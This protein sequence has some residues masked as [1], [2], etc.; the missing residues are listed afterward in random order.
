MKN[1]FFFLILSIAGIFSSI[2]KNLPAESRQILITEFMA[3]NSKTLADEDGDA[4]DWIELYN[5]GDTSVNLSGWFLT[6]KADNLAKWEIPDITLGAGKYLLVFAS[7]KKRSDP[8]KNLHTNFKLS[9]SGEFLAIV[10]PDGT[11]ISCSF[12]EMF[13]A[14]QED[15]SYGLYLGQLV[16]FN[17]PT[18]G[19]E[20]IL[21]GQA[22]APQ[23]SQ[24]RG[25]YDAPFDVSLTIPGGGA[26]IYYT[27][28]GA[29]PTK[30]SGTLYQNPVHIQTTTPLSAVSI[31]LSNIP[32]EVITHTY[33]FI[34]SIVKQPDNPKGYPSEWSPFKFS[35]GN[36]PADYEMDPEVCNNSSYKDLMDDALK[37]IPS[38]SIVTDIGYLFSQLRDG[39]KGGIYIYTGNTGVG[40]LGGEWERPVSAEYFDPQTKKQFQINCGLR[41]HGGNSRIPE[42]SQKHSFRLSFRSLYGPSKLNFNLFDE[43][44]AVSEYNSLVIRAGYNYSWV[45]NAADQRLNAQ[46]LQDPFAKNSQLDMGHFSAHERFVHLYLN[47]LYW[48]LYNLSEKLT[49]DFMESYMGGQEDDFDVVKDHS[50]IVDGNLTAWTKLISQANGGLSSNEA[51]RKIQGENPDGSI[52]L[53]YANLL[54]I[55]NLIDFMQL[56]MY[57]GNEDWD[58]NNWIAA[59]N[60]V[61][62]DAGFRF[63]SWDAETSMVDVNYNNTN[64]NNAGNPSAIYN[65]LSSNNDFKILF[66]DH[67]QK[68][69]FNGGPLTPEAA[70]A[71]YTNLADEINLAIIAE[72]ARWGDYRKDAHASDNTRILYTRNE[73]WLPKKQKLLSDYFP[74][75]SAVVVQQFREIG[76]FPNINAPVFSHNGGD[77]VSAIDL[78]MSTNYGDIY[79]TTDGSDPRTQVTGNIVPQAKR[80][81]GA[82][83]LEADVTV[84]ARAKSGD[85]W[86]AITEAEFRFDPNTFSG[87][88][89][90]SAGM[91]FGNYPNP[92]SQSTT[93]FYTLPE[94]GD[95]QIAIIGIDGKLIQTLFE[96]YQPQGIY[97]LKWEPGTTRRGIFLCRIRFKNQDYFGKLVRN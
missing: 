90:E 37:S 55:E 75:R 70:I 40:S 8:S 83:R 5:P 39:E 7:E 82:V 72:S 69:F 66:A 62:N 89:Q 3:L 46:Y 36:A 14:Q 2:P 42:N 59:R 22:L 28:D 23:F 65:K 52:N 26:E 29:R 96:G 43:S 86:S 93:I 35:S 95:V 47:G 78:G 9:G 53:S 50:G 85:E 31:N 56:N 32:S 91:D 58:H 92:F 73:H 71:R 38:L 34:D 48:G 51:Y 21:E 4:S 79:Y 63:F 57:I 11:T 87:K 12:G 33:F 15:V 16:Y 13:P 74:Y 84:R 24:T 94:N 18:P 76:L 41:L 77:M 54:D 49:N 19:S 1:R 61:T 30:E 45:K 27:T 67:V 97:R 25:F 80:Y 60:R 81:E 17:R 44:T 20:N 68:N 6:D 88:N 10:E 64:E